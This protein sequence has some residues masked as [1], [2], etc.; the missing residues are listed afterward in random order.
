[1]AEF[2]GG[3]ELISGLRPKNNGQ[4]P[5]MQAQDVAFYEDGKEV[6]LTEKL[7]LLKDENYQRKMAF[8]IFCGIIDYH[9]SI[10]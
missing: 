9:N 8:S 5:L 3:I 6:R 10:R 4:F 1:M 7:E 2:K